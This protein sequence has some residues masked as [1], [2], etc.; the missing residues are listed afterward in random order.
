MTLEIFRVRRLPDYSTYVITCKPFQ[1]R[2]QVISTTRFPNNPP[3]QKT[4]RVATVQYS[5]VL[6]CLD[7][8]AHAVLAFDDVP[9]ALFETTR[10]G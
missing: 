7:S 1:T 9:A 3:I 2:L 6:S 5:K 10:E 8:P 4:L